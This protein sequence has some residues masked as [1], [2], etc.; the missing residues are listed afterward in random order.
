MILRSLRASDVS[1]ALGTIPR[2]FNTVALSLC[3]L[4]HQLI[5]TVS[6]CDSQVSLQTGEKF[7]QGLEKGEGSKMVPGEWKRCALF[8]AA[9]FA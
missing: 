2:Y 1:F 6:L 4:T 3:L 9:V 7:Y 5:L 8:A